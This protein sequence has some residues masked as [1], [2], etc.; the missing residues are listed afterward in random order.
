MSVFKNYAKYYDLLYQDKNYVQEAEYVQSLLKKYAPSAKTLFEMGSGTG[1]HAIELAKLDYSIDGIDL[2]EEM[3][4]GAAQRVK[5]LP[6]ELADRLSFAPGDIRT[7][8]AEKTYDAVIS[9]FHI[10]SYMPSNQD[11]GSMFANARK[12]LNKGGA[13]LF[14]VWYGPTVLSDRPVVRAKMFEN[15]HT[16]VIRIARPE[17]HANENLVDVNYQILIIDK[18]TNTVEEINE[19]HVMRYLFTPELEQFLAK[20][21]FELVNAEEWLTGKPAGTDTFGTCF[22]AIAQ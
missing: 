8:E 10:V 1:I 20:A 13:F 12:K 17:L 18:K 4:E 7:F 16:K 11:L 21:G 5:N 3:L 6:K 22:A 15:E 14:D 9:L 19:K 2:S